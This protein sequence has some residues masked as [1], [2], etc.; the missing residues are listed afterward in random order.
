[1]TVR[2]AGI[3]CCPGSVAQPAN[4]SPVGD[5][6]AIRGESAVREGSAARPVWQDHIHERERWTRLLQ[7]H[8]I[9]A[10][11]ADFRLNPPPARTDRPAAT[12][13][14]PGAAYASRLWPEARF[15]K[16]AA[17]LAQTGHDVVFTGSLGNGP[18]PSVLPRSRVSARNVFLLESSPWD[19]LRP[20]LQNRGCWF[21]PIP[22]PPTS[23]QPTGAR[24]SCSSGRLPP[25]NGDHRRDLMRC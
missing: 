15:A 1:M 10:D 8:G 7:W 4:G 11:P 23:P 21:P 5:G 2:S 18:A 22:A 24:Q 9:E 16:V 3:L 17:E 14:H 6:R 25:R 13:I 12:V 20:W 19:R